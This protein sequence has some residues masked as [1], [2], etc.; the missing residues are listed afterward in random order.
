ML[1]LG[2]IVTL[3]QDNIHSL[4]VISMMQDFEIAAQSIDDISTILDSR[5]EILF[6]SQSTTTTT[7]TSRVT[8]EGCTT[9]TTLL[10]TCHHTQSFH[11]TTRCIRLD[12][13][14]YRGGR[15]GGGGVVI[16]PP[17]GVDEQLVMLLHASTVQLL[18]GLA[19]FLNDLCMMMM[20]MMMIHVVQFNENLISISINVINR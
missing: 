13:S 8:I 10:T 16:T 14:C 12:R 5:Q 20:M 11:F 17:L 19:Q 18:Y 9:P 7:T 6:Q 2:D 1:I 15:G 3:P 4:Q